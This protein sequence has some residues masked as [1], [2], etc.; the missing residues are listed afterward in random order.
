MTGPL[1]V[2][3]IYKTYGSQGLFNFM[4]IE[5]IWVLEKW[6]LEQKCKTAFQK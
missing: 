3:I 6:V 5:T 2:G 1:L 4:L